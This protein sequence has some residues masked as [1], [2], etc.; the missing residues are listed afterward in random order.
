MARELPKLDFSPAPE[1]QKERLSRWLAEWKEEVKIDRMIGELP[2]SELTRELECLGD[3][4]QT[5]D[6]IFRTR[7][8]TIVLLSPELTPS[9]DFPVYMALLRDW[10]NESILCAPYSRFSEPATPGELL[11]GRKEAP[12]RVLQ[13]WNARTVPASVL[14]QSWFVDSLSETEMNEAWAV[15]RSTISGQI[16][17]RLTERLGPPVIHP[18]DPR[19]R[20]QEGEIQLLAKLQEES[21]AAF[22]LNLALAAL[23]GM[24]R[25]ELDEFFDD[26][27]CAPAAQYAAATGE[28]TTEVSVVTEAELRD[29]LLEEEARNRVNEPPIPATKLTARVVD[30]L[31]QD[32]DSPDEAFV[33]W[34]FAPPVEQCDHFAVI[35]R[36]SG[37]RLGAGRLRENGRLAVLRGRWS[38]LKDYTDQA[39]FSRLHILLLRKEDESG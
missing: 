29:L 13:V 24:N 11:T 8:G 33:T 31:Q 15:F 37:A 7:P 20:Y 23:E 3:L 30:L 12:L 27:R 39:A 28:V 2:D 21:R 5:T 1:W 6:G 25:R 22:S 32:A 18:E 36:S 17:E 16:P 10:D 35:D 34:E 14:V 26:R 9:A 38:R 19:I 4:A